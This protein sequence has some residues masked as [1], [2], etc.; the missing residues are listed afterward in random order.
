MAKINEIGQEILNENKKID[1]LVQEID[2][3]KHEVDHSITQENNKKSQ[4][5]ADKFQVLNIALKQ[6]QIMKDEAVQAMKEFRNLHGYV[7]AIIP[8]QDADSERQFQTI[9]LEFQNNE[10][11]IQEFVEKIKRVE[12]EIEREEFKNNKNLTEQ[13]QLLDEKIEVVELQK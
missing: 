10:K 5:I 8:N 2:N 6:L 9:Q 1:S 7:K 12:G 3:L 11:L 4:M 13:L